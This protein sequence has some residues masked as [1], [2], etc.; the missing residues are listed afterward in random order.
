M[1]DVSCCYGIKS[2]LAIIMLLA[3]GTAYGGDETW[4]LASPPKTPT[5]AAEPPLM[6]AC[7][8]YF[9]HVNIGFYSVTI[10][11]TPDDAGSTEEWRMKLE[12]RRKKS[13]SIPLDRKSIDVDVKDR[14]NSATGIT[15][16]IQKYVSL[17]AQFSDA[18]IAVTGSETDAWPNPDDPLPG[19][20]YNFIVS[21]ICGS[22]VVDANI[23]ANSWFYTDVCGKTSDGKRSACFRWYAE[24]VPKPPTK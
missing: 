23:Y 11:K 20:P 12:L 9:A 19:I 22:R 18:A 4:S 15:Y 2:I 10:Y 5:P 8:D 21:G 14:I 13:D 3:F 1:E 7:Q 16:K 17:P 6:V 24:F